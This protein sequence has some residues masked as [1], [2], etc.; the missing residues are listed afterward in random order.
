MNTLI[1]ED[2]FAC[3]K[4]LQTVLGQFGPCDVAVNGNEAMIA[5][6]DSLNDNKPYDLVCLDIMMPSMNG[7]E[8][9]SEIRRIEALN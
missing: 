3:R 2:V 1:V 8:T 9:L 6:Q 7:H 5:F 4:F